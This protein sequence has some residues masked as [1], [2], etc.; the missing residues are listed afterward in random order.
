MAKAANANAANAG[1]MLPSAAKVMP[2]TLSVAAELMYQT[3]V[4]R[5]GLGRL[6][7]LSR[8]GCFPADVLD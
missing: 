5:L 4:P 1:S 6:F 2:Q 7:I 8:T 3:R